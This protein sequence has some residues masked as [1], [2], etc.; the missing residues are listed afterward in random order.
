[1]RDRDRVRENIK[2]ALKNYSVEG[3]MINGQES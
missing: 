2:F 3:C 1:M